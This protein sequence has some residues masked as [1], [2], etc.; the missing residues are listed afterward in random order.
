MAQ[1]NYKAQQIANWETHTIL[2]RHNF[3]N[4]SKEHVPHRLGRHASAPPQ[5][6]YA[7]IF[8]KPN[9]RMNAVNTT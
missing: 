5:S 4:L 6:P 3:G 8:P 1:R 9:L 7:H 2:K